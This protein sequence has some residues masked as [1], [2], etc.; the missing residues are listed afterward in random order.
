MY[1][2]MTGPYART[3]CGPH[4]ATG[5]GHMMWATVAYYGWEPARICLPMF[6][7]TVPPSGVGYEYVSFCPMPVSSPTELPLVIVCSLHVRVVMTG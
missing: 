5:M 1:L 6:S 4:H 7:V 3:L 2:C